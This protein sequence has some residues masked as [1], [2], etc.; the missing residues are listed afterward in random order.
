MLCNHSEDTAEFVKLEQEFVTDPPITQVP[1][2]C[3]N[4]VT[5][6]EHRATLRVQGEI[7]IGQLLEVV[8]KIRNGFTSEACA[9]YSRLRKL[10]EVHGTSSDSEADNL[11]D[12]DSE[13]DFDDGYNIWV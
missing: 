1:L 2:Y 13:N 3:S 10:P 5:R 8:A 9:V 7:R 6:P 12:E 11:S 4:L